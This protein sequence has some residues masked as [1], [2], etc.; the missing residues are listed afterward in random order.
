[1]NLFANLREAG[2]CWRHGRLSVRDLWSWKSVH[3]PLRSIVSASV[4]MVIAGPAD[5]RSNPAARTLRLGPV[6]LSSPSAVARLAGIL[7]SRGE[8]HAPKTV[9]AQMPWFQR[10]AVYAG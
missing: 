4:R 7:G 2:F 9:A 8:R 3:E 6:R 10:G 5:T 1:M